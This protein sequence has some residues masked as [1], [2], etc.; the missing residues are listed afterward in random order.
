MHSF[1]TLYTATYRPVTCSV[2]YQLPDESFEFEVG[3]GLP[4]DKEN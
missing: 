2:H 4:A 3:T 1:G